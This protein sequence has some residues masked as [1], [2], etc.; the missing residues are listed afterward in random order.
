MTTEQACRPWERSYPEGLRWDVPIEVKYVHEQLDHTA[1][2]WPHRPALEFM[3]LV[4]SYGELQQIVNRAAAGMRQIGVEPGVH[5]GLYLPNTPH[6]VISFLAILKAGGTV[7]NYSPLDAERSLESKIEDSRT[8]IMITVDLEPLY[9]RMRALLDRSRL[10]R[11]VVGNYAEFSDHPVMRANGLR[12][13]SMVALVDADS[14]ITPFSKLLDTPIGQWEL[15]LAPPAEQVAVLQYTGGTTGAPKGAMLTHANLSAACEQ[16]WWTVNGRHKVLEVGVE[17]ILTVLPLFH[18]YALTATM[19]FGIRLAAHV[20]L[21]PRFDVANVVQDLQDKA[22]T[23][24]PG[25]PTMFAAIST[26]PGIEAFNLATLKFCGSGGAPLPVEVYERFRSLTGCPLLEGWGMTE[27]CATGT[28]TPLHGKH[29][30][31]ACGI[32]VPGMSVRLLSVADGHDVALGEPG[33]ICVRGPNITH[34]YWN[35]PELSDSAFTEDGY[36]RTGDVGYLDADGYLHIVDRTKDMILCSG[37]NVYPRFI[38]EA[39]YEH[40]AVAEVSV[41]GINDPYRGQSPKAFVALK[42]GVEELSLDALQSFLR[43]R[44]GKHEM[45]HALEIRDQL[46]KTAIGKLSKKELYEE[47]RLRDAT[48][49]SARCAVMA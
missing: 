19:L 4:L 26:F 24:F 29:K 10:V 27:T 14:R 32:P 28:F 37:F 13:Q 6:Y 21:H 47:E 9:S 20:V 7:V 44:V 11:L 30:A 1:A 35:Q 38:E 17:K 36:F 43:E 25:V 22:I 40:P 48:P 46:P 3:G 16:Y 12:A 8:D 45:V 33:E 39:I 34:G 18:I 23:V 2:Q 31:G 42:P 49:Q 15:R 41:I 5:V